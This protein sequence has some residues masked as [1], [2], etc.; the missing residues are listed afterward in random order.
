MKGP[1]CTPDLLFDAILLVLD[2]FFNEI[3]HFSVLLF[4]ILA[5]QCKKASPKLT[6]NTQ[7]PSSFWGCR[8]QTSGDV[9]R[10]GGCCP[11]GTRWGLARFHAPAR[12]DGG[13]LAAR[14][15]RAPTVAQARA[16]SARE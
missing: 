4:L 8:L 3:P 15:V 1:K 6:Q 10:L 11:F 12:T 16:Y 7:T 14:L 2:L 13:F 9:G 5:S